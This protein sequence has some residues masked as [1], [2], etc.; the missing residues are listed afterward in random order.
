MTEPE[1]RAA[2]AHEDFCR[3]LAACYY[4]PEP[5]FEEEGLFNSLLDA[6]ALA[7]ERLVPYARRLGEE[8][9]TTGTEGLLLDYTRLFLGPCH[10]LA[11]PYGSVWLEDGKTLMGDST[12]EVLDLYGE[13]GFEVDEAFADLP[14]H[15]AVELEFL[16]LLLFRENEARMSG[17]DERLGI[18]IDLE[19]R[20]LAQHLGRWMG[21]FAAAA[22]ESAGCEFYR[23]LA[24]V[25]ELFVG[26]QVARTNELHAMERESCG[27]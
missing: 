21:K 5:A 12:M 16:Y 27:S 9:R 4:E 10:T 1:L 13:A 8:F 20:F 25:T 15:V 22:K 18:I 23:Q 14:D 2:V 3:Y 24:E 19:R 11:P 7:D 17:D 26:I 6:A